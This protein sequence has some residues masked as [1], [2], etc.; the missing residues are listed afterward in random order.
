M[1]PEVNVFKCTGCGVC[2]KGCPVGII[3]LVNGKAAILRMLCEECGICAFVCPPVAIVNEVSQPKC[4][5]GITLARIKA[6]K[7]SPTVAALIKIAR[8]VVSRVASRISR[9]LEWRLASS[10]RRQRK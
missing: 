2:V 3:G 9:G 10:R 6:R 4:R 1:V 7:P 8:P 5:S